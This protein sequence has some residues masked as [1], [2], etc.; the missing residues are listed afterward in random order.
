MTI[1]LHDHTETLHVGRVSTATV[2]ELARML[3]GTSVRLRIRP[4]EGDVQVRDPGYF[5][6]AVAL[7]H[8]TWNQD[9]EYQ[10]YLAGRIPDPR[11]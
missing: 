5:G 6:L 4:D 7:A 11:D 8:D 10:A 3:D 2:L 9:E 1:I